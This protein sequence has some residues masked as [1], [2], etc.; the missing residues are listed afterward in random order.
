MHAP[1]QLNRRNARGGLVDQEH[2]ATEHFAVHVLQITPQVALALAECQAQQAHE[3]G[4][5]VTA[6]WLHDKGLLDEDL[7]QL[8]QGW[9]DVWLGL[10]PLRSEAHTSEL[11]SLMRIS[12]AVFCLK[13]KKHT[14]KN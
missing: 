1:K 14:N 9:L 13:T 3:N 4:K 11:Q 2:V 7:Q 10:T 12:Y 5:V 8:F 6:T